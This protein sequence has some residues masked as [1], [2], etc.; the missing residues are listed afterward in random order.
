MA[1]FKCD[2]AAMKSVWEDVEKIRETLE[3]AYALGEDVLGNIQGKNGW[4]GEAQ[5][6]MEA[7]MDLLLQY[8]GALGKGND[9]PEIGRASC[10]ER[11]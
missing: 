10:R 4:T 2:G 7:F 11:V 5:K 8:H 9:S 3:S 6:T 1:K